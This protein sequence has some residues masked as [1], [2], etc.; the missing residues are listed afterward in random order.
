MVV[1]TWL[2]NLVIWIMRQDG[3][4]GGGTPLG[5]A[6]ILRLLRLLRLSRMLRMLRSM[7][8][9]LILIKGM[10]E[11][12]SSV[13]FVMILQIILMYVFAIGFTQLCRDTAVGEEFFPTITMSMYSLLVYG[14]FLDALAEL[15][16]SL[17]NNDSDLK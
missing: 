8:E 1:E 10:V 16:N 17:I 5:N 7:P 9:L 6:S 2:I 11:A 14:V 3:G 4:G 12:F 15:T 13:V